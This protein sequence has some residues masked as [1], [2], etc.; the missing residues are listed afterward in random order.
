MQRAGL[1]TS[2]QQQQ[3]L[4]ISPLDERKDDAIQQPPVGSTIPIDRRREQTN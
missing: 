1:E 2:F 3:H 4:R